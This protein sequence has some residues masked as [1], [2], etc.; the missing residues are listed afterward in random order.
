MKYLEIY[1][2]KERERFQ[3]W[4]EAFTDAESPERRAARYYIVAETVYRFL[5]LGLIALLIL[6]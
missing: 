5:A 1:K 3:I 6:L 2:N 4:R